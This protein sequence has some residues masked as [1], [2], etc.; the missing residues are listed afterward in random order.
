MRRT[1]G[2]ALLVFLCACAVHL[3]GLGNG[4][5]YDD[6]HSLVDNPHV[7]SLE[8]IPLFFSDPSTFS[9][10][11]EN[12]MY[13]PLLL[14]SYALNYALTGA[15][16][17][18]Y[19]LF[20]TLLHG[21]NAALVFL[22][23]LALCQHANRA[24]IAALFFA[25]N[26]LSAET[27]NYISSRS[28]LL[29]TS[30][31]LGACLAY[32][33]FGR[34]GSWLCYGMAVAGGILALLVKSVAVVLVAVL[35]LCDWFLR[36]PRKWLGRW[37]YY[38]VFIALDL[39]Y[40]FSTRQLVGKALLEPVR[41]FD[42]QLWTQIKALIYYK[43]LAF[44]PVKLSVEH[45]FFTADR[46]GEGAV[47]VGGIV[48]LSLFLLL[49]YRGPRVLRFSLA[50]WILVLLPTLVVPLYVLVNEHRLYLAGVGFGLALAWVFCRLLERQRR[51]AL[52]GFA[53]YIIILSC[54]TFQRNQVWAD[55]LSLWRDAAAKGPQMVKP[56]LRLA[57]ALVQRGRSTAD[58]A[59]KQV[60]A[61]AAEASYL[62]ALKLRSQHP[63]GRNNLGL[64]YLNQGRLAEARQ[65]F[66]A[67]LKVSPDIVPAR[68]NLARLSMQ[69][70][71]WKEAAEHYR[72]AL[73]YDDTEGVAQGYLGYI[74]LQHR[75]EAERALE[76]YDRALAHAGAEKIRLL[77]GRGAALKAL[78]HPE[79]A[80][81]AYRAALQL[82]ST[83]VDAWF[84][85]GNL[86]RATGRGSAAAN[87]YRQVVKIGA[88]A[89]LLSRA[90]NELKQLKP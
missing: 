48:L 13:R 69:Q 21:V 72:Q 4:F 67:L 63:G 45:Q 88:D 83:Y 34:T 44:M 14:S 7:R 18:G 32:I 41:G 73:E 38:L 75:G 43:M 89:D 58:P 46:P 26:P 61:E 79:E 53:C 20:N 6:F 11:P 70:G 66:Q 85:L 2:R 25:V 59:A 27:V 87:A 31:F 35:I 33:R 50:W 55:E 71:R 80:E 56:H 86:Y 78:Q 5:H 81:K 65:Q 54:L 19:H 74:A 10:R 12:A 22:L 30:F 77:L 39:V 68:L 51:L 52:C 1:S 57:D 15:S 82:D 9:V 17:S 24:L 36:D 90:K 8:N 23:L 47:L 84:N 49:L 37:R 29:M 40:I 28:E 64:L 76:Y 16:P 60:Y 3:N 42:V 62:R